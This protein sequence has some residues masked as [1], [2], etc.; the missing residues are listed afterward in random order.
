MGVSGG[1]ALRQLRQGKL[2]VLG[3]IVALSILIYKEDEHA[4]ARSVGL[5]PLAYDRT[6]WAAAS[7]ARAYAAATSLSPGLTFS[8][9]IVWRSMTSNAVRVASHPAVHSARTRAPVPAS[10]RPQFSLDAVDG[11]PNGHRLDPPP[12][13]YPGV[14]HAPGRRRRVSPAPT[15]SARAGV[16]HPKPRWAVGCV[17]EKRSNS[18]Q[19]GI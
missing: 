17:K 10:S 12:L 2:C 13:R 7:V 6:A 14:G 4:E 3:G 1:P 16:R 5:L 19:K 9:E 8:S 11:V 15:E 18:V